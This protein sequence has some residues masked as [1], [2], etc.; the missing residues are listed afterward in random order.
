MTLKRSLAVLVPVLL[1]VMGA[2]ASAAVKGGKYSGT[3]S[4]GDT[5]AGKLSITVGK[6]S[7]KGSRSFRVKFSQMVIRCADPSGGALDG[8]RFN[9][10][11]DSKGTI[12]LSSSGKFSTSFRNGDGSTGYTITGK[13]GAD[14]ITGTLREVFLYDVDAKLDPQGSVGCSTGKLKYSIPRK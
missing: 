14:K 7:S 8:Q 3:I 4:G 6:A 12:T 9:T 11:Q 10:K 1:L 2:Q 5:S 13:V